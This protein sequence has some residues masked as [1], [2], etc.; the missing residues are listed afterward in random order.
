[1]DA[2]LLSKVADPFTTSR[3]SRKVGLGIP[4]LKEAAEACNG[5][6]SITSKPGM[7]TQLEINFQRSHIDRMPMGDIQTTLLSLVT[8]NPDLDFLFHYQIDDRSY[9]LD[10]GPI[11]KELEDVSLSD[12]LVIKYLRESISEG[13]ADLHQNNS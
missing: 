12:P 3:L 13:L 10:T 8:L 6:F 7:G 4:L 1:M 2:D 5:S 9:F 11:K